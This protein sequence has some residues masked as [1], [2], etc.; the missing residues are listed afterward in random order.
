MP[1][2][3]NRRRFLWR[4]RAPVSSSEIRRIER[5][6]ATSR[7]FLAIASVFAMWLQPT[8]GLSGVMLPG[9]GLYLVASVILMF[10][11][12]Y[13]E[14]PP[15]SLRWI[16]HIID[17]LWPVLLATFTRNQSTAYFLFFFFALLAAA[18]RFG[19]WETLATAAVVI[20]LPVHLAAALTRAHLLLSPPPELEASRLFERSVSLLVMALLLGYLA[21]QEKE[22]RAEKVVVARLLG[23]ARVEI[24][25]GGTLREILHEMLLMYG[26]SQALLAA[27]ETNSFRVFLG[28]TELS[29]EFSWLPSEIA[30][31]DRYFFPAEARVWHASRSGDAWRLTALDSEGM[32]LRNPD[33]T[34]LASLAQVYAFSSIAIVSINFGKEWNGRIYL[35]DPTLLADRPE[36]LRFLLE[37][38]RQVGP[39]VYNVFLLRR[40]R[41]RAGAVERARVARELHDG[42]IQSVIASEMQVD[43]L[44]REAEKK[45]D[46]FALDLSRLQRLLRE[47]A[48]KLRDL[49]Q[50]VKSSDVN[51][52]NLAGFLADQAERF[53]REAGIEARFLSEVAEVHVSTKVCRELARIAQEALVNI[54]KHSHAKNVLIRLGETDGHC[55]LAVEDDGKGFEF[56]GRLSEDE[57]ERLRLGPLVI[58]E[59][60]RLIDGSLTVESKPGK[61]AR[62]E[63]SV[64]LPQESNHG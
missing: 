63:V 11:F 6:L 9:L 19:L 42:A 46:S 17:T 55:N 54:R 24:G 28:R 36:E 44:R 51:G 49:M 61:G 38:V 18:Y 5:W 48:L 52:Q 59:R 35:L 23:K 20:A 60:V 13:R 58:R 3:I 1:Y 41:Q 16:V 37:L 2:R 57:L 62:L 25:M 45:G 34:F 27:E 22:L 50:H 29:K 21:E 43:I 40:L 39:A 32:R 33:A 15:P 56:S 14:T 47:E 64:L 8:L 12:R 10:L 30:D 4:L 26:A 53:Q 31:H 7:V